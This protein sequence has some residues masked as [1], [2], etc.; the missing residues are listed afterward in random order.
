MFSISTLHIL[1]VN[2]IKLAPRMHFFI[3]FQFFPFF[4]FMKHIF[5]T[6]NLLK[7]ATKLS[8]R[9]LL[10]ILSGFLRNFQKIFDQFCETQYGKQKKFCFCC[11]TEKNL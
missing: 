7:K 8:F 3:R 10:I 2:L 9:L 1:L 6:K 4:R 5:V 11:Q